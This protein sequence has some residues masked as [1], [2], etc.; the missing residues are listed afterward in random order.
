MRTST[1]SACILCVGLMSLLIPGGA[2]ALDPGRVQQDLHI[3]ESPADDVENVPDGR[4]GKE[5]LEAGRHI[6]VVALQ[7]GTHHTQILSNTLHD[8]AGGIWTGN[9][10][11]MSNRMAENSIYLNQGNG[12]AI[13]SVF[14]TPGNETVIAYNEIYSNDWTVG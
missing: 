12:I 7:D 1:L 6:S 11:G 4:P 5:L 14:C 8:N 2:R 13:D 9:D 3:R 10:V